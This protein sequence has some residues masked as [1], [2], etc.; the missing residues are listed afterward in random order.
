MITAAQAI[1]RARDR[2]QAF[3][4]QRCPDAL[5]LRALSDYC[6][7]LHGKIIAIDDSAIALEQ[8][9]PLPLAD[10]AAGVTLPPN[11]YLHDVTV[12][13]TDGTPWPV[14]VIPYAARFD[15]QRGVGRYAWVIGGVLYLRGTAEAWNLF[16]ELRVRYVPV[17]AELTTL[18]DAL[19]VPDLA[20]GACAAHLAYVFACRGHAD[21][22]LPEIV[23]PSF[24][25]KAERAEAEYLEDVA[26]RRTARVIRTRDVRGY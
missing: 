20:L 16:T 11:R 1:E 4:R 15:H 17:P 18:N 14:D 22:A 7:A 23:L 19:P 13:A 10:F 25:Q 5:A 24:E 9:T 3:D 6:R 21:P 8:V 26:N 12:I 2:H